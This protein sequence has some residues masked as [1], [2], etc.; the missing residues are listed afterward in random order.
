MLGLWPSLLFLVFAGQVRS[1]ADP[2]TF[3]PLYEQ[4]LAEQEKELGPDHPKVAR[5][6]SDLG[7]FMKSV[8]DLKAA[9]APLRKALKID[10]AHE[11]LKVSEDRENLALVLE[12]LGKP[13]EAFALLQQA[14][15]GRDAVVAARAYAVL[16]ALDPARAESY[17]RSAVVAEEAASGKE[18]PRV[19]ILLNDLA[20]A[21]RQRDENAAA[22]PLFRRALAIQTKA[23]GAN[24]AAVASTLNNLGSL[25]Q[26]TSRLPEAERAEREALRIFEQRFGAERQGTGDDSFQSRRSALDEG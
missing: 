26:A 10:E 22:E 14:A 13:D 4:V 6:A 2:A 19:A 16:A 21:L 18:H 7:L 12:P 1:P 25:L 17:Y 20:L 24:H 15:K 11:D 3:A 8:G 9:E 5:S 23:L